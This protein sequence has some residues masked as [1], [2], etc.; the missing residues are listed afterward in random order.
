MPTPAEELQQ[1][2]LDPTRWE[3]VRQEIRPREMTS[4]DGTMTAT[5][6]DGVLMLRRRG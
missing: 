5:V 6:K 2:A 3:V 1:L 4:P